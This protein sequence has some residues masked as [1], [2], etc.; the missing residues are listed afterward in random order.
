MLHP[1]W[2]THRVSAAMSNPPLYLTPFITFIMLI[3][4]FSAD[5]S[6]ASFANELVSNGGFV[7]RH[8]PS[9]PVRDGWYGVFDPALP[10]YASMWDPVIVSQDRVLYDGAYIDDYG[11]KDASEHQPVSGDQCFKIVRQ[12]SYRQLNT[13]QIERITPSG[14]ITVLTW[15]KQP[16]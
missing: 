9:T 11:C 12:N 8:N 16:D 10:S 5:T 13:I 3:Q 14:K 4:G 2:P 6:R 15:Y 1:S 7:A